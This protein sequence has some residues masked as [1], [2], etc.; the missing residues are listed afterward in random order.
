MLAMLRV[1][2]DRPKYSFS[3]STSPMFEPLKS[4]ASLPAS[5]S[6]VSLPS[7][8][9]HWK[10]S[11]P[12]PISATSALMLPSTWSLPLPPSSTSEPLPPRRLSAP[13]PPSKVSRLEMV[14]PSA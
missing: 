3:S 1:K 10:R 4:T 9:S 2:S 11:L 14:L 5:P 12:L 8:G 6:T 13:A 7:P